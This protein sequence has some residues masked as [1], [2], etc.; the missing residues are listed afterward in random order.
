MVECLAY[1]QDVASSNLAMPIKEENF[2][3]KLIKKLDEIFAKYGVAE[4]DI[5]EEEELRATE[6]FGLFLVPGLLLVLLAG[7]LSRGRFAGRAARKAKV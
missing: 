5:A 1:I 6:R 3:E 4:E 2:M 7:T